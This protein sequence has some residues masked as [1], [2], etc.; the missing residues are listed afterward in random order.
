MN[1]FLDTTETIPDNV[2]FSMFGGIHIAWLVFFLIVVVMN[3]FLYN[4]LQLKGRCI[5]RKVVA[6]LI[7]LDEL[8][9]MAM[10]AFGNRY[11]LSYL[12]LHLCSI[13][14]FIVAIYTFKPNTT[15]GAFLYTVCIPG[16][17]AALIFPSWSSL[18]FGNFMHMHSFTVHI[19][20]ALYPI[21]LCVGGDIKVD[22]KSIP[23]CLL[24]LVCMAIPIYIV[25]LLLDTNF[26][27]LMYADEG[28]PLQIFK[29]L[30]GSHLLGYPVIIAGVLIVMYMPVLIF[31]KISERRKPPV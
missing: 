18:P 28:N 6:G 7:V 5:W 31:K 27:F 13:N 12:P 22:V 15:I 24:M 14:I 26:M 20:L 2:G 29:Q 11:T 30:W 17:L 3:C 16:A 8:F 1:Y 25:N 10:L 4:S 19:L 23:K 21:V 9:K